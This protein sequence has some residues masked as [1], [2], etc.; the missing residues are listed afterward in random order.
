LGLSKP[1]AV[2]ANSFPFLN[3]GTR[4]QVCKSLDA[5]QSWDFLLE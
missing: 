2:K 3:A 1:G 4:S 5:S